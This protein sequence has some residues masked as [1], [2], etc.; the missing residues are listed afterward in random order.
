MFDTALVVVARYPQA[1]QTKTRLARVIGDE[2]T[3]KLY[4]AFLSDL[5]RRFAGYHY[6]LHWAYTPAGADYQA[7]VTGL[8][9]EYAQ[10][11]QC[12]PQV[13][14]D[15]GARLHNIF[16]WTYAHGYA[17]TIL[18]GSDS[19]HISRELV[20]RASSALDQA[21]V[22]LGPADDGG[23]YL[24]AMCKPYDVFSGIPMST[25]VVARM[26]VAAAQR[27]HL[28]VELI[29]SLF[30]IDEFPDLLRLAQLLRVD[31]TCAPATAA[32]LDS[33]RRMQ[34]DNAFEPDNACDA[35][36]RAATLDLH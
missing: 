5:A 15:F 35:S 4:R 11:M 18:I 13:G 21:D 7:L 28:T 30:D 33:M 27:Q 20:D 10:R 22:V 31:R 9:P 1:G 3:V 6:D 32:H 16:R 24:L 29:D 12:F 14:E 25:E 36:A 34:D 17:R 2:E 8:A 26:T 23:Y 19:P